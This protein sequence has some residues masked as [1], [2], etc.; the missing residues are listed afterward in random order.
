MFR[1]PPATRHTLICKN[2][3]EQ[4]KAR[5]RRVTNNKYSR[6]HPT[7][8]SDASAVVAAA[9]AA[10]A[11]CANGPPDATQQQVQ[12]SVNQHMAPQQVAPQM[13]QAAQ[14]QAQTHVPPHTAPPPVH[15]PPPQP[16]PPP[17]QQPSFSFKPATNGP[18]GT[19]QD[20]NALQNMQSPRHI[21]ANVVTGMNGA[22]PGVMHTTPM[23]SGLPMR[24]ALLNERSRAVGHMGALSPATTD[25]L[26]ANNQRILAH[27]GLPDGS[28]SLERAHAALAGA[29]I[30]A[31]FSGPNRKKEGS[32]PTP[33][34]FRA[35]LHE[36]KD[37]VRSKAKRQR[38]EA[39]A[40]SQRLQ[41]AISFLVGSRSVGGNRGVE[42]ESDDSDDELGVAGQ[43]GG[44]R[45]ADWTNGYDRK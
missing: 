40:E 34:E 13:E 4:V 33:A 25:I 16:P 24:T 37:S 20:P 2:A 31:L 26:Y 9:A 27:D 1:A 6:R 45:R 44:G 41:N 14:N 17:P 28:T 30:E 10:A 23:D 12:A 36:A 43:V 38:N 7:L 18:D 35:A 22:S 5:L 19:H 21:T 42:G 15:Q 11:V 29:V 3:P 8:G 32:V 39:R